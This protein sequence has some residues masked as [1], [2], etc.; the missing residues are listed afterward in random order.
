VKLNNHLINS[1]SQ[2]NQE[3]IMLPIFE[4][5]QKIFTCG[6][7]KMDGTKAN[8]FCRRLRDYLNPDICT[9]LN[10][11]MMNGPVHLDQE[12][13]EGDFRGSLTKRVQQWLWKT[14]EIQFIDQ[15]NI[16]NDLLTKANK[17]QI[18]FNLYAKLSKR[19]DWSAGDFGDGGSCYWG[20]NSITKCFLDD[21]NKFYALQVFRK[22]T[23]LSKDQ[24]KTYE[25]SKSKK[26]IVQ[27]NNVYEGFGRCLLAIDFPAE[28]CILAWNAY[29]DG[30]M[31]GHFVT[32][33]IEVYK[34]LCPEI[35][36]ELS[37]KQVKFLNEGRGDGWF[38]TNNRAIEM[39]GPKDTLAGYTS[40]DIGRPNKPN[41]KKLAKYIG[42]CSCRKRAI[43]DDQRHQTIH[44]S[45]LNTTELFCQSCTDNGTIPC[46]ICG[47]EKLVFWA[48]RQM[49]FDEVIKLVYD[50]GSRGHHLCTDCFNKSDKSKWRDS[51]YVHI[52]KEA[53]E[54][55]GKEYK[56]IPDPLELPDENMMDME[57]DEVVEYE[58]Q[59]EV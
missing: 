2:E 8:D 33:L 17:N 34:K 59:L 35:G 27:D 12:R 52:Y 43:W 9:A 13:K 15:S 41:E 58:E 5:I 23:G 44:S 7:V 40:V 31:V 10:D 3:I 49:L 56:S 54:S 39:V 45:L 28:N 14:H 29:P 25:K 50:N 47:E 16:L 18:T 6:E 37:I 32:G 48:E 22:I 11:A 21:W 51:H 57:E 1:L 55:L 26:Y 19:M 36:K 30:A 53:L 46:S 38:Y 42:Y 4:G 24:I 20:G